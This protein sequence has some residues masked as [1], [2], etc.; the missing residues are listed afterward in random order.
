MLSLN[1]RDFGFK[2]STEESTE[3]NFPLLL[4]VLGQRGIK[5]GNR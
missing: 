4:I 5:S 2:E 1:P 3:A